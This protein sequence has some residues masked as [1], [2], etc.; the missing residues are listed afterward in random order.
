L[1]EGFVSYAHADTV[2]CGELRRHLKPVEASFDVK[3]WWDAYNNTGQRFDDG[4]ANAIHRAR[5]Y[6]LLVSSNFLWSEYIMDDEVPAI[7]SKS[8]ISRDLI[9]PVVLD[10]CAWKSL[11]GSLLASPRDDNMNLR[12]ICDWR[13]RNKA[14]DRVREQIAT[15]IAD[16]FDLEPKPLV[17]WSV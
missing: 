13:T 15:A 11:V 9:L 2:A 14:L 6:I 5:V 16:H 7:A 3:F 17:D 12:P 1:L 8:K 4:I 10:H